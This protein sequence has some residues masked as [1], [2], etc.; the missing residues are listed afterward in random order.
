MPF[1]FV[2]TLFDSGAADTGGGSSLFD[3]TSWFG[4]SSSPVDPAQ[5]F[6]DPSTGGAFNSSSGTGYDNGYGGL[7]TNSGGGY[8]LGAYDENGN[9]MPGYQLD[10]NNNPVYTGGTTTGPEYG[11][12]GPAGPGTVGGTGMPQVPGT[13]GMQQ[14]GPPNPY[15]NGQSP[16]YNYPGGMNNPY[17]TNPQGGSTSLM[18]SLGK[19][20]G[21][22]GGNTAQGGGSSSSMDWLLPLLGGAAAGYLLPKALGGGSSGTTVV[23]PNY[24]D[25]FSNIKLPSYNP[26]QQPIVGMNPGYQMT[27]T[28][29]PTGPVSPKV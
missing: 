25:Q 22:G 24:Y 1:D 10:E 21:F 13:G 8:N 27:G 7:T 17:G 19:L 2:S 12:Q 16:N 18:G 4:G 14:A 6:T 15:A 29:L 11:Q 9:L 5:Y 3:P 26:G 20:L 23:A 28:V